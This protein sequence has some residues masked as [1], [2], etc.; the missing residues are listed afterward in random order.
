MPPLG[1]A[2]ADTSVRLTWNRS[3]TGLAEFGRY[4]VHVDN[5]NQFIIFQVERNKVIVHHVRRTVSTY[6]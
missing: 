1:S 6:E 3:R 2:T 4:K 5:L